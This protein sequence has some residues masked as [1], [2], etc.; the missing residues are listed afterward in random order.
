MLI[1]SKMV[2]IEVRVVLG[3]M[4]VVCLYVNNIIYTV[5][6]LSL[7]EEFKRKMVGEFEMLD[8]GLLYYFF[9]S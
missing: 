8:L 7:I 6:Q 9:R 3:D 2:S 1:F 4:L 5:P